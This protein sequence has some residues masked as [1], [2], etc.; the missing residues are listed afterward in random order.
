MDGVS[1][2][3]VVVVTLYLLG[4]HTLGRAP[5]AAVLGHKPIDDNSAYK[6]PD[7]ESDL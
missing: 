4:R 3:G 2:S 5:I 7:I 6:E 1:A